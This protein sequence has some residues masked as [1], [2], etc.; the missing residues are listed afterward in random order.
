[1]MVRVAPHPGDD[2]PV[3]TTITSGNAATTGRRIEAAEEVR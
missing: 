1:M 2:L 3:S